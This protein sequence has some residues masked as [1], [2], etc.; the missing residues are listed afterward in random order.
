MFRRL[1]APEPPREEPV[2]SG[3]DVLA[4]AGLA[5]TFT[6]KAGIGL[7]GMAGHGY[8]IRKV[9]FN[10]CMET[11]PRSLQAAALPAWVALLLKGSTVA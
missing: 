8:V 6:A 4:A 7:A 1:T 3:A 11:T 10:L 5:F 2:V 9:L